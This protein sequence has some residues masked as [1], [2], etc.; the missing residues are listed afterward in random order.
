MCILGLGLGAVPLSCAGFPIGF[1][2][3]CK[4]SGT[5][6]VS[7]M[8]PF[9]EIASKRVQLPDGVITGCADDV[10]LAVASIRSL[11]IVYD[12]FDVFHV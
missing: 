3:G 10:G 6:F 2:Q 8:N 11:V 12:V 7:G 1:V 9:F 4:L 5:I